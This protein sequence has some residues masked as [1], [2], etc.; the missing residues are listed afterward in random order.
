ME[1]TAVALAVKP[2][3]VELIVVDEETIAVTV[4]VL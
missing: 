3:A 2:I 4:V 1:A